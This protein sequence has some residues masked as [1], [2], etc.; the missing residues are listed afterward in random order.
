[1]SWFEAVAVLLAAG[2]LAGIVGAL[3]APH[4]RQVLDQRPLTLAPIGLVSVHGGD[5][6]TSRSAE[7]PHYARKN[8]RALEEP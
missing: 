8:V 7:R 1:M 3:A 4:R 5:F 6:G 2:A